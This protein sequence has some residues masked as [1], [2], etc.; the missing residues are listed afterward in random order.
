MIERL[1][2]VECE[3]CEWYERVY[4]GRD[5]RCSERQLFCGQVED[6]SLASRHNSLVFRFWLDRNNRPVDVDL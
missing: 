3:R 4:D 5:K 6:F 2:R 1:V